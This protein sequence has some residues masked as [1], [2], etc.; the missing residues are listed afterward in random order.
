MWQKKNDLM[1]DLIYDQA[2]ENEL[3]HHGILGM[4][5]GVRRFQP[6]GQGYDPL[7]EGKEVGLAARMGGGHGSFSSTYGRGRSKS[8]MAKAALRNFGG[9]AK[10]GLKEGIERAEY[11]A[12]RFGRGVQ[13]AGRK[14]REALLDYGATISTPSGHR[15]VD[16]MLR[17]LIDFGGKDNKALARNVRR[18]FAEDVKQKVSDIRKTSWD[19]VRSAMGDGASRFQES[20]AKTKIASKQFSTNA[21]ATMA[22]LRGAM[23][24]S[25][26]D[27]IYGKKANEKVTPIKQYG[28]TRDTDKDVSDWLKFN[29]DFEEGAGMRYSPEA[30]KV[31]ASRSGGYFDDAYR[32]QLDKLDKKT[33]EDTSRSAMIRKA[34]RQTGASLATRSGADLITQAIDQKSKLQPLKKYSTLEALARTAPVESGRFGRTTTKIYDPGTNKGIDRNDPE[35]SDGDFVSAY[36]N[37][38][39]PELSTN[40]KYQARRMKALGISLEPISQISSSS[41]TDIGKRLLGL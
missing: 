33:L 1:L 3:Y 12:D 6:Y 4:R 23:G 18:Q 32:R 17:A 15:R 30:H 19:D 41:S 14:S 28:R 9:R 2:E 16:P 5:W 31:V 7:H 11:A 36:R 39:H 25:S 24:G 35:W 40:A 8:E 22:L 21:Q 34:D 20:M 26:A 10:K 27:I 37:P 13:N 29:K 38:M